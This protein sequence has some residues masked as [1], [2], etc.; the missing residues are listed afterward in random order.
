MVLL[1]LRDG[2]IGSTPIDTLA[3]N[4]GNPNDWDSSIGEKMTI[5]NFVMHVKYSKECP[6]RVSPERWQAMLRQWELYSDDITR[7]FFQG[8]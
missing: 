7:L 2:N 5:W 8:D 4:D 3:M 1:S 6:S